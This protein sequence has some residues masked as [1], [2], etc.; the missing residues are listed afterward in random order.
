MGL[1]IFEKEVGLVG[2]LRGPL[3][4]YKRRART[5]VMVA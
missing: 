1:I 2:P 3:Q 5:G 4:D